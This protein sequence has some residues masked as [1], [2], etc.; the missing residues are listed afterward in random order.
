MQIIEKY[1]VKTQYLNILE[2]ELFDTQRQK[3]DDAQKKNLVLKYL[4]M[5]L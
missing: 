1:T 4:Y 5:W 3:V 2:V